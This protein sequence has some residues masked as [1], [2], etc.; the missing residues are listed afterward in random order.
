MDAENCNDDGMLMLSTEQEAKID[1]LTDMGFTYI[2][3]LE[4]LQSN[5]WNLESATDALLLAPESLSRMTS[6]TDELPPPPLEPCPLS[7]DSTM[8]L[9]LFKVVN[10]SGDVAEATRVLSKMALAYREGSLTM[11]HRQKLKS[12][13]VSGRSLFEIEIELDESTSSATDSMRAFL[14]PN[15]AARLNLFREISGDAYYRT[16]GTSATSAPRSPPAAVVQ[17]RALK[18]EQDEEFEEAMRRDLEAMELKARQ[19]EIMKAEA[20]RAEAVVCRRLQLV[21]SYRQ[22]R[23]RR[24]DGRTSSHPVR[25]AVHCN[26][27]NFPP[28]CQDAPSSNREVFFFTREEVSSPGG[29][30][31]LQSLVTGLLLDLWIKCQESSAPPPTPS[32]HTFAD[33]AT[34]T[35]PTVT[36]SASAGGDVPSTLSAELTGISEVEALRGLEFSICLTMP[37]RKICAVIDGVATIDSQEDGQPL[38]L[39]TCNLRSGGNVRVEEID[40]CW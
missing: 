38:S 36:S 20:M 19:A 37:M 18:Q 27:N 34:D 17:T 3:S 24:Q 9:E 32:T 31:A 1:L 28:N 13:L 14:S 26:T 16:I 11:D 39:E 6:L 23:A 21:E 40:C 4:S 25:I 33:P 10:G 29:V 15:E 5:N 35:K 22:D 12:Q 30:I 8:K 7:R 2:K